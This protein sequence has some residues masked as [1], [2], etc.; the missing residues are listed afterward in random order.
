M[1]VSVLAYFFGIYVLISTLGVKSWITFLYMISVAIT[2]A[3]NG[4]SIE[5]YV[6]LTK[7]L[8]KMLSE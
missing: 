3:Y 5:H 7:K 1:V 8:F 6:E 2:V 4:A